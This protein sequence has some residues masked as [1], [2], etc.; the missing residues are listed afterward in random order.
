M[1]YTEHRKGKI[2][3]MK[4]LPPNVGDW[5]RY[6]EGVEVGS[7][8]YNKGKYVYIIRLADGRIFQLN[9]GREMK[10]TEGRGLFGMRSEFSDVTRNDDGTFT[11]DAQWYNGGAGLTEMVVGQFI[12]ELN[13]SVTDEG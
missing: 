11:F 1:S 2:K 6:Q 13:K 5:C 4:K 8:P 12:D 3:P 9:Q 10:L 7:T